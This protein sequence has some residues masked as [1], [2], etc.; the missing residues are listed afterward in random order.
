[1]EQQNKVDDKKTQGQMAERIEES[2]VTHPLCALFECLLKHNL[3]K[4]VHICCIRW[5]FNKHSKEEC[6]F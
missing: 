5:C 3:T 4:L 1:V 6:L 2:K